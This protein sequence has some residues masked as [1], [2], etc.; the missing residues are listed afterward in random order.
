MYG[1]MLV[2]ENN[3]SEWKKKHAMD[4]LQKLLSTPLEEVLP[5]K[6]GQ[7]LFYLVQL[8]LVDVTNFVLISTTKSVLLMKKHFKHQVT[9][10]LPPFVKSDHV[11][12]LV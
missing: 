3:I 9:L 2:Q 7:W 5:E 12:V 10:T 6:I 8:V 1:K 11:T 4:A